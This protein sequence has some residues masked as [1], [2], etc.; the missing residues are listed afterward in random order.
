MSAS[1]TTIPTFQNFGQL[2]RYLGDIPAERIRMVPAP[3]HATEA[4]A[5]RLSEVNNFCELVYGTLVEKPMGAPEGFFTAQLLMLLGFFAKSAGNL[6]HFYGPDTLV[7]FSED[8]VRLPDI[9]FFKWDR[10]PNRKR[11]N[12]PIFD[13]IPNLAIEVLS[14]SNTRKE[15]ALKK[16]EYFKAGVELMWI[17]DI[18]KRT[19]QVYTSLE[20]PGVLL[21]ES[22]TLTGGNVLPGFSIT[23]P[24][25]FACLDEEAPAN[26]AS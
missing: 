19:V 12:T 16:K 5:L 1:L 23:L 10:Y 22:D 3:G 8:A 6:G 17:I 18:D 4:D 20:D 25:M 24:E 21:Q 7:R 14:P 15:L 11:P 26:N 2:L 9:S 13:V